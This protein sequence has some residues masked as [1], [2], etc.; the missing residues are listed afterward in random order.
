MPG[1]LKGDLRG[2]NK[3]RRARK[4]FLL[5]TFGDGVTCPCR[6][7]GER[8]DY[9][10]LTADR[11]PLCG[12]AG[13]RYTRDNVVPACANCNF[14]RCSKCIDDNAS[15]WRQTAWFESI[16]GQTRR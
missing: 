9:K 10:T 12:H 11:Y 4:H 2:S 6:W 3:N 5:T 8:L 7:C 16:I 1:R 13:G 15:H 14:G